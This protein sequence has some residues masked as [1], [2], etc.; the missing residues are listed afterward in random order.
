MRTELTFQ[1]M[2][3]R[4]MPVAVTLLVAVA[5][6][7]SPHKA[8]AEGLFDLFFG[9]LEAGLLHARWTEAKTH[10][11]RFQHLGDSSPNLNEFIYTVWFILLPR[12]RDCGL[13][14]CM[15]GSG[16]ISVTW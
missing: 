15:D 13:G 10:F 12:L 14:C 2:R 16:M 1:R 9:G 6:G 5:F 3:R 8:S 4:M 7:L 11:A